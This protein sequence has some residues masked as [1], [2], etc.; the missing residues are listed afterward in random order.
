MRASICFSSPLLQPIFDRYSTGLQTLAGTFPPSVLQRLL[1]FQVLGAPV[2]LSARSVA[3]LTPLR[4]S[5]QELNALEEHLDD[6]VS[7]RDLARAAGPA[8][9]AALADLERRLGEALGRRARL[10]RQLRAAF[11]PHWESLFREGRAASRFG[12]QVME[13]ACIYTSRVS[14]FLGY[15]ADK[16]FSRPLEVLPHERWALPE[17]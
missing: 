3:G 14:N 15:P 12:R 8:H 11:N 10:Q 16:F 2:E 1:V 17:S 6:L 5:W 7:A 9:A 4:G 13:F